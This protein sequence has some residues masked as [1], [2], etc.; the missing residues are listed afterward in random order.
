MYIDGHFVPYYGMLPITKGWHAVRKKPM[1]G[2]YHFIVVDEEFTPWMFLLR[3]SSEDLLDRIPELIDKA[4]SIEGDRPMEGQTDIIVV[5]DRE[6]YSAPLYSYLDG[7]DRADGKRR[8]TFISWAKY[9]DWVYEV[10]EEEFDRSVVVRYKIQKEKEYKYYETERKMSKYGKIR[11]IVVQREAD[12][13]RSVIYTNASKEE[14]DTETIVRIICRRW[15]EE[16][17]IK[18]LMEKHFIDYTPGYVRESM[19]EQPMVDNPKVIELK[20]KKSELTTS[21]HKFKV[22]FTDKVLKEVDEER[23]L[24]EVKRAQIELLQEI[25]SAENKILLITLEIDRLPA[26][27]RFDQAHA[28]KRLSKLDYEK[29]RFLDCI[30]LF[31]YNLQMKM[32]ELLLNHYGKQKEILPALSMILNRSGHVKLESGV[33]RVRLGSFKNPE[34]DYAARRLCEDVNAMSPR[35]LDTFQ[36]PIHYEIM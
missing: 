32:C 16:N 19:V 36:H 3:S 20:K 8:A 24:K 34:I 27:V 28:G 7:R 35:T 30:K 10:P 6:G 26:E 11:T 17:L 1:K 5:F 29:K 2:S 18:S 12:G 15:G 13:K 31:S 33:L 25:V 23:R 22:K 21:L 14:L 9:S 4:Q